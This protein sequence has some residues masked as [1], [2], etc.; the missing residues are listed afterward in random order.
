[1]GYDGCATSAL[2]KTL[3]AAR[4]LRSLDVDRLPSGDDLEEVISTLCSIQKAAIENFN[5]KASS[6]GVK[7]YS[8]DLYDQVA[9]IAEATDTLAIAC[10]LFQRGV[11]P[12]KLAHGVS[13]TKN[14]NTKI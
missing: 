2:V 5:S 3:N 13:L 12:R 8:R 1:M 6:N 9:A 4:N 14:G 10:G 7:M 11:T